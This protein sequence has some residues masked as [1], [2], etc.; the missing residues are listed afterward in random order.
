MTTI[1][2]GGGIMGVVTA[3]YLARSGRAVTV[4]ERNDGVGRETSFQ[5]GALLA[6]GHSQAW[7]GPGAVGTLIKSLFQDDPALRFRLSANP[8]FWLWGLRFLANCNSAA[9]RAN[10]LRIL[11]CMMAGHEVLRELS[12]ET[13]VGYDGNDAGILYVFRTEQSFEANA[14]SWTL[15]REHGLA[16]EEV[17]RDRCAAIEPALEPTKD[18]VGG[19]FFAPGDGSGDAYV[20]TRELA[21][22]CASEG[23]EFRYGTTVRGLKAAG[24]RIEAVVTDRGEIPGDE[25]LLA[26]GAYSPAIGRPLGVSLPIW[27]VKGYTVSVPIDGYN[28]TPRAGVIDED[29]LVAFAH[30]GGHMRVG[31]KAEFAG[32]DTSYRDADFRGVFKVARDLFPD[33]GDYDNAKPW[34]CLRPATPG[35]PPILGRTRHKNLYLNVGHGAAGWTMACATSRAVANIMS[36]RAPELDMEG[37]TLN[38]T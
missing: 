33:G 9:Y 31:G 2:L 27:P 18:K 26:L 15:L 28:G 38:G 35:G 7:A 24:D 22:R 13:G 21:A 5:N 19:G 8:R 11:R 36:G 4:I 30:L 14:G 29:N 25:F 20:F 12:A 37:L 32:Y 3:Y 17:D 23:V 10:T 6:P 1:V 34:A 16:L